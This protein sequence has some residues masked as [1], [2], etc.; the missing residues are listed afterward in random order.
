M[1]G[2]CPDR[3][4]RLT[5]VRNTNHPA[6]RLLA[7]LRHATEARKRPVIGVDRKEPAGGQNGAFGPNSDMEALRRRDRGAVDGPFQRASAPVPAF[8]RELINESV[9]RPRS[10]QITTHHINAARG[11]SQNRDSIANMAES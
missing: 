8:L 1:A 9:S 6:G 11:T 7:P 2:V 10:I 4:G 5:I 3:G